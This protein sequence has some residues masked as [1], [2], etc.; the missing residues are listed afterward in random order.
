MKN[1]ALILAICG[2]LLSGTAD[3]AN[4]LT[5]MGAKSC[6]EWVKRRAEKGWPAIVL[7]HWV[8]GFLSGIAVGNNNDILK[9]AEGESLMLW[10]D[11]YCQDNPLDDT[12]D[13]AQQLANQLSRKNASRDK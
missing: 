10:M 1:K 2:A 4:S 9:G 13:A 11:N 8:T 12:W 5:Y 7:G 3:A 6:G